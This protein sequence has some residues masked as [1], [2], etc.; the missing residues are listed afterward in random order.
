VNVG[1]IQW[2]VPGIGELKTVGNPF[3]AIDLSKIMD[4]GVKGDDGP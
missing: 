2:F 3:A 4:G 1:D